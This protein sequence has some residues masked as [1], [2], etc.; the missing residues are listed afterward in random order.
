M[1]DKDAAVALWGMKAA[2]NTIPSVLKNPLLNNTTCATG[3]CAEAAGAGVALPEPGLSGP[4]GEGLG[5]R[6]RTAARAK[7]PVTAA[8]RRVRR[9]SGVL[10][11]HVLKKRSML[12]ALGTRFNCIDEQG[13]GMLAHRLSSGR[14]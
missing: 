6:A 13:W 12:G 1:K 4:A 5:F 11:V 3:S 8:T 10:R 2:K 9:M 7:A 14:G